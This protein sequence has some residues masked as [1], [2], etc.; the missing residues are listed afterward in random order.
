MAVALRRLRVQGIAESS[1]STLLA[2]LLSRALR[3]PSLGCPRLGAWEACRAVGDVSVRTGQAASGRLRAAATPGPGGGRSVYSG[4]GS[5]GAG[6]RGASQ[7]PRGG[8]SSGGG[9]GSVSGGSR[10]SGRSSGEPSGSGRG[11]SPDEPSLR[12]GGRQLPSSPTLAPGG[13]RTSAAA[14]VGKQ[15]KTGPGPSNAAAGPGSRSAGQA[16]AESGG[17]PVHQPTSPSSSSFA[18]T[19]PPAPASAA[20]SPH[21]LLALLHAVV[22]PLE[23]AGFAHWAVRR[24]AA[25][26]QGAAPPLD[27][28]GP[29][30]GPGRREGEV[31]GGG[32]AAAGEASCSAAAGASTEAALEVEVQWDQ[33][34]TVHAMFGAA[35]SGWAVGP[36]EPL[37]GGREG[38]AMRPSPPHPS[39]AV[40]VRVGCVPNTSLRANPSRVRVR[41]RP[42]PLHEPFNAEAGPPGPGPGDEEALSVLVAAPVAGGSGRGGGGN[43]GRAAEPMVW[44]QSLA[45]LAAEAGRSGDT[46]LAGAVGAALARMQRA[47]SARNAAAWGRDGAFEAWVA[48]LG[49]PEE[50]GPRLAAAP[51]RALGPLLTYLTLPG[52]PPLAGLRVANLCGSHGA[53]AVALAALGAEVTVVDASAS[54]GAYARALASAA[55]VGPRV[56]Y[57]VG[58]LAA[59]R[60]EPAEAGQEEAS[61]SAP[62]SAPSSG[63]PSA[64]RLPAACFDLVLM[65]LGVLHYFLDLGAL[66]RDVVSPLL[67][68]RGRLLLREFHPVS[69][70][71]LSSRGAKHKVTGDYFA[72]QPLAEVDVAYS[73]YE[74]EAAAA[75]APS[76]SSSASSASS[77]SSTSPAAPGEAPAASPGANWGG[78]GPRPRVLERRWSLGEVVSAVAGGPGA[79]GGG[80]RVLLLDEEAGPRLDDAGVPKLYTLLAEKS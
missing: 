21:P 65:E 74:A 7:R 22:T 12:G 34:R 40:V 47:L 68:P 35:G 38:F 79:G 26:L 60:V 36:L 13:A 52:S 46:A 78:A 27:S 24:T 42:P 20:P 54:S 77:P 50:A 43:G 75:S 76:S 6:G 73:K 28:W 16:V 9:G 72:S 64:P 59:L 57:L 8:S 15:V 53:K 33:M 63:P 37:T 55:G 1:P 3:G 80:L 45:S 4:A 61:P 48:R 30:E 39:L 56:R 11:H 67:A 17:S 58:D 44:V 49:P 70:K 66:M 23:A 69:T 18:A 29:G 62:S 14:A 32:S 19:P 51:G 41:P 71:L 5:S 25:W 10:R 2:A 31:E